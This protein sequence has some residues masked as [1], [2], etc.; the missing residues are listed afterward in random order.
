MVV[1]RD[2]TISDLSEKFDG[3]NDDIR[4]N[5]ETPQPNKLVFKDY[6]SVDYIKGKLKQAQ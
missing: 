1:E 4:D 3:L 2:S 6:D 5:A